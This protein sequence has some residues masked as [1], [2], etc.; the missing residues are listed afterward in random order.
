M[1]DAHFDNIAQ[2]SP[3]GHIHPGTKILLAVGALILCILSPS[4]FVP[5]ISGI[6]LSLTLLI[7]GKVSSR[8]YGK[9]LLGPAVFTVV[10]VIVIIF[11]LGGGDVLWNAPFL[12]FSLTITTYSLGEGIQILCRVFG[13]SVSLFFIILTTP[14]S[15]IL[16]S[17]RRL[18][19]P[20]ELVD[21]MMIIYRYIFIVYD[22]AVEIIQAQIMRLGYSRPRQ[23][24]HDCAMLF[25]MLFISSWNAGE[26]LITAMDAR[27]YNGIFPALEQPESIQMQTLLPVL[28]YLGFLTVVL[29]LSA[30]YT[31]YALI[32]EIF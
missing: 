6:V 3:L 30:Q 27:C 7:F 14:L 21:L 1:I 26:S 29:V 28:L 4:P 13:S 5:I 22:Q 15:D 17:M 9:M 8:L 25:G 32:C 18:G 2:Q 19:F 16:S 12:W 23:A 24:F 11:M 20:A 10:S 31:I